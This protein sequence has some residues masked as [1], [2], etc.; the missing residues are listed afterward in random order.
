MD[1][2][3]LEG[4]WNWLMKYALNLARDK[5]FTGR[6]GSMGAKKDG[7]DKMDVNAA[8]F[9]GP[10]GLNGMGKDKAHRG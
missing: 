3:D 1:G 6:E 8:G 9:G 5:Y 10:P 4:K 7:Q 2:M